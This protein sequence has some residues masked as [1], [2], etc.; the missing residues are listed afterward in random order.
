MSV[1]K[2]CVLPQDQLGTLTGKWRTTPVPIA[3][4]QGDFNSSEA[5]QIVQAATTWNEFYAASLGLAPI[6]FGGATPRTS[7]G[8]RPSGVDLCSQGVVQGS[9]YSGPIVLYKNSVWQFPD[10]PTVIALTSF[11]RTQ[12]T[13]L[14]YFYMQIIDL[15][16]Q[17]FFSTGKKQP[18][19]QTIVLHEFG[20][21]LG[22]NH[23]CEAEARTGVPKCSDPNLNPVY[24]SA[25]MFP[26][27]GFDSGTGQGVIKR[28][29]NTNDQGRANCLYMNFSN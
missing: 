16:Y 23:T 15:N 11:C 6:D 2:E 19:L 1:V 5:A 9:T 17:N 3:L 12:A 13:P 29:L 22:L 20:H 24:V 28:S 8:N 7:S 21:L 25:L 14:P 4:H 10:Q 18:D 27:F 26:T